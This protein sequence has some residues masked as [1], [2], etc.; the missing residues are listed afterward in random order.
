M[1]VRCLVLC[2]CLA[3]AACGNGSA[4]TADATSYPD[5]CAPVAALPAGATPTVATYPTIIIRDKS[6][7]PSFIHGAC[8]ASPGLDFDCAGLYRGGKLIAVVN[9][10]VYLP[11]SATGCVDLHTAAT[12]AEGPLDGH[13]FQ[14]SSQDSGY[15]SLN[16]GA[17]QLTFGGCN[18]GSSILDCDGQGITMPVQSGDEIDV[19]E[20]DSNYL[21]NSDTAA[22][23]NAWSGCTCYADE[24]ELNL[25]PAP[26][27]GSGAV[28]LPT[29][30][31]ANPANGK[32]YAGSSTIHVP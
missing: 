20:V 32:W 9:S 30:C 16:G 5:G 29:R 21:L 4:S 13:V 14:D 25:W 28:L 6:A 17:L 2:A 24:F 23:G 18:S 11:A 19:W 22:D 15:I 12:A 7:D 3:L 1:S 10:A 31:D 27:D 8:G 26:G